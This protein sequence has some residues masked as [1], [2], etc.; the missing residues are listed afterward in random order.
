MTD[1]FGNIFEDESS[2]VSTASFEWLY[3]VL[4]G[5]ESVVA[6]AELGVDG[7]QVYEAWINERYYDAG[8][9]IGQASFVVIDEV[10][11]LWNTYIA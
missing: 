1:S 4:K 3:T 6:L 5:G 11:D 9:F 10:V 2:E 7:E 8:N